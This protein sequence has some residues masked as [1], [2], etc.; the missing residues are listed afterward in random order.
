[1]TEVPVNCEQCP[2]TKFGSCAFSKPIMPLSYDET[3]EGLPLV[4]G[5][6]CPYVLLRRKEEECFALSA[7][8]CIHPSVIYTEEGEGLLC[9]YAQIELLL[10]DA[11]RAVLAARC[12]YCADTGRRTGHY[13]P[14]WEYFDMP[15]DKCSQRRTYLPKVK[16]ALHAHQKLNEMVGGE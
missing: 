3:G 15:C 14:D 9:R 5:P 11:L 16:E 10:I 8:Q 13:V 7:Q 12:H 1:M 4:P 6:K 2:I